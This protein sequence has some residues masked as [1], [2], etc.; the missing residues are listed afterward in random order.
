MD[1]IFIAAAKRSPIGKLNGALSGLSAAA[2]GAQVIRAIIDEQDIDPMVIDDVMIG[3]VLQ[4]GTGQNPARQAAIAAG[5]PAQVPAITLNMVCGAGQRSIHFA[6][7][8]I[9]AGDADLVIAGGQDSMTDAPHFIRVR[10]PARMGNQTAQDMIISDGLWDVFNDIH[11]GAT[12]EQLA[13]RYQISRDE[14]DCFALA[15]QTKAAH[16]ISAGRFETEI[17]PVTVSGRNGNITV[18]A[19]EHP[20]P[21]TTREEL[22]LMRPAF[23]ADGTITAGNA[24]GLNDGASA[25][26]VGSKRRLRA[27]GLEPL[28][29]IASYASAALDPMDMG[30]GPAFASRKALIKAGWRV[31]DLD[32]LEINEAFAAQAIAVNREMGWDPDLINTNGGAIALGH[33]LAG[34]GNRIVVTLVHEMVRRGAKRGLASLCIGG[35][36]GVAIC[37]ER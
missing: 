4:G 11:M 8:A 34:S 19:D 32:V 33:P 16:A 2:T 17:T 20:R 13:R 12:V 5:I 1:S 23:E 29:R 37:L 24:S 10:R 26:L 6:A 22:A 28:A 9:K 7:Q 31:Q 3:Q 30:L 15:S 27:L 36:Q 14:Q 18:Q 21:E 25:V 35:G